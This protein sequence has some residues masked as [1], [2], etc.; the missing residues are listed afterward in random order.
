VRESILRLYHAA[1]SPLRH[2]AASMRGLYLKRWRYGPETDRLAEEARERESW[3]KERWD[4]WQEERLARLL[5][6][7]ATRVPYYREL[8]SARRRAGET[9]PVE[10]LSS[11]PVLKKSAVRANPRAFLA[12]DRHPRDM[13]QESTS[14]T[15]G[16]PLT[17]WWSRETVRNW[18][19]LFE[20]RVRGWN[21]V[22]RQDRWAMLGGQLVTPVSRRRPPFWVENHP[23]SQLYLSSYHL[24]PANGAAYAAAL[25]RFRPEYLFGY[26][27]SLHALAE[28]IRHSQSTPPSVRVAISNAEPLWPHQRAAI[29]EVF[30]CPVRDTYGMAEIVLAGSEC[31]E[32]RMHAWP[33][34]GI[35][36]VLSDGQD[37]PISGDAAG[38]FVATGLLNADMPLIRYDTGDRGRP[39][40][41]DPCA[42]GRGLSSYGEIE[43]RSDD[44]LVTPDGRR[45]GR[46]DPVFKEA[47]AIREAQIVQESPGRVRVRV[48]P[49]EGFGAASASRITRALQDRLGAEV[50]VIVETVDAI[51]RGSA[52]KFRAV[53]RGGKDAA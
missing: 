27:S 5:H 3:S 21:G 53:V 43:G 40:S 28:M 37:A 50:E 24:A 52:G 25:R 29:G 13:F 47:S 20:A 1:P 51:S 45:V 26:A 9:A 30:G 38:R 42:C 44:V 14:G 36:E 23:L 31:G 12:D 15:T 7:A 22:S 17:L 34:V 39:L 11:W 48:V 8:W 19:A 35:L 6:R 10:V 32:E 16:S 2:A 18:Y 33:E 49:A 41:A 4:R 46:L